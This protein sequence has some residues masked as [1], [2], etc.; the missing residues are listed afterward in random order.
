VIDRDKWKGI[1][2]QAQAHSGLKKNN[3]KN[4]QLQ[5]NHVARM[6]SVAAVLYLHFILYV[7]LFPMLTVLYFYISTLRIVCSA[8]YGCLL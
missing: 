1:V 7:K 4:L 8:Q 2:R 5:T 6:Y 3:K